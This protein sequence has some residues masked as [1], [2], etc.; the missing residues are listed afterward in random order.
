MHFYSTKA[1]FQRVE[2]SGLYLYRDNIFSKKAVFFPFKRMFGRT[3]L[4]TG[5]SESGKT[6]ITSEFIRFI[7]RE[8][9]NQEI[10][11]D[12]LEI[13]VI[14]MAPQR[15]KVNHKHFGGKITDF[16]HDLVS[17]EGIH[18]N[19]C[20][21][22]IPPRTNAKSCTEVIRASCENF[23]TIYPILKS[24]SQKIEKKCES[25]QI[26][27][28][29]LII[30]DLSIYLHT[31]SIKIITDLIRLQKKYP[32]N[33]TFFFN[34]YKG[35]DLVNDFGSNISSR[36]KLTVNYISN[37]ADFSIQLIKEK[38]LVI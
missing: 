30:N 23:N 13:L 28:I 10:S 11:I 24:N 21:P 27:Q 8:Q 25:S 32:K 15:F 7:L 4:I 36:E 38:N 12:K 35:K 37:I 5:E 20:E 33:I 1:H 16:F 34:A 29:F 17:K 18:Y 26:R 31:G 3:T 19:N 2:N 14:D 9:E 22:I 6:E